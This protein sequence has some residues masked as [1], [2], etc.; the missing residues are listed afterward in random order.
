MTKT[1]LRVYDVKKDALTTY[2]KPI[3]A[4]PL[5]AIRSIERLM[6]NLGDDYR[7]HEQGLNIKAHIL[8]KNMFEFQLKDEFLPIY[9]NNQYTKMFKD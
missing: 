9:T 7:I 1:A 8:V 3:I 6:I 5:I 4:I 2:G